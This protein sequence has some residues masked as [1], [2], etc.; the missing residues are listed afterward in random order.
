MSTTLST[1]E[2]NCESLLSP[3]EIEDFTVTSAIVDRYHEKFT[4]LT[5]DALRETI[6]AHFVAEDPDGFPPFINGEVH[7][8][9]DEIFGDQPA[10]EED[11][12]VCGDCGKP[13]YCECGPDKP[14]ECGKSCTCEQDDREYLEKILSDLK[15]RRESN[16]GAWHD[17]NSR[18][19]GMSF[20]P[21]FEPREAKR[22]EECEAYLGGHSFL[23]HGI[24]QLIRATSW[25]TDVPEPF[26]ALMVLFTFSSAC[27]KGLQVSFKPGEQTSL[28][29][30]AL[31]LARSGT[32]KTRAGKILCGPLTDIHAEH[33]KEWETQ[34][35]PRLDVKK[36]ALTG[37]LNKLSKLYEKEE[38]DELLD[39]MVKAQAELDQV[40]RELN[41]PTIY[42]EDV[43]VERLA[44]LLPLS[45]EQ[46]TY[47]SSDAGAAIQNVLGKYNKDSRPD[48]HILLKS[49]SLEPFS[50]A[51]LTRE[52]VNLESPWGS[53]LWMTQ[54]DKWEHLSKNQWLR[55]GGFLPRCLLAEFE[56]EP[57]DDDGTE[58]SVP[59]PLLDHYNA[60]FRAIFNAYRKPAETGE[61]PKIIKVSKYAAELMRK[62]HNE[63]AEYRRKNNAIDAFA[64]RWVEN[65]KRIAGALHAAYFGSKAH[66]CELHWV[67][68][69]YAIKVMRWFMERQEKL[70]QNHVEETD[71]EDYERFR[72][73][74]AKVG[75]CMTMR[76]IEKMR[77]SEVTIRKWAE[78]IGTHK[79]W[80]H[81]GPNGTWKHEGVI[82]EEPV[83]KI[84][85]VRNMN[86]SVT[87]YVHHYSIRPEEL[88]NRQKNGA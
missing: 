73:K 78:K 35:K 54:P 7:T 55:E 82:T 31:A 75:R 88:T 74:F 81:D 85:E 87:K 79:Y 3:E 86:G 46:M 50:Q 33:K 42:L 76:E 65:A 77:I 17:G 66:E 64:A 30:Y 45:G 72:K 26:C 10:T 22:D 43:T 36:K 4:E 69:H 18:W 71:N 53:L 40:D 19:Y 15:D 8:R 1:P 41:P 38:S 24:T 84:T 49:Y 12:D 28:G 61:A 32:G 44:A 47:Y 16:V 27:G 39:Q 56:C 60:K 5:S 37:K 80:N 23:D 25:A 83:L 11:L 29:I 34:I 13:S 51:R 2:V 57:K 63:V 20:N 14:C 52:D 70:L 21:V 9:L 62:F 59:Q 68:V 58:K 67:M 6:T 48:D